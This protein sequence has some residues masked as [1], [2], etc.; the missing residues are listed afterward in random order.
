MCLRNF[1]QIKIN[2]TCP[3][4]EP[5][6]SVPDY[7]ALSGIVFFFLFFVFFFAQTAYLNL[8]SYYITSLFYSQLSLKEQSLATTENAE[9]NEPRFQK[10]PWWKVWSC[11]SHFVWT[12]VQRQWVSPGANLCHVDFK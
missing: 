6:Y 7:C 11:G 2:K 8:T 12:V 5:H 1:V 4:D 3:V 10:K 9:I